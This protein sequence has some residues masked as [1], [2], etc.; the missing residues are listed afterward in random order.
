MVVPEVDEILE[1][2]TQPPKA[3]AGQVGG[4]WE[5]GPIRL[6]TNYIEREARN[7]PL[8]ECW[9]GVAAASLVASFPG[10]GACAETLPPAPQRSA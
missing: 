1:V 4:V 5:P 9:V 8:I 3:A 7:R 6:T 2:L 10:L